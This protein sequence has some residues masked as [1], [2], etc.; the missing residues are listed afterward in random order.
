MYVYIYVNLFFLQKIM[1][2]LAKKLEATVQADNNDLEEF[3]PNKFFIF[4]RN[5][6]EV[7]CFKDSI[8]YGL[9]SGVAGGIGTYLFTSKSRLSS[10]VFMSTFVGV[11]AVYFSIARYQYEKEHDT[12]PKMQAHLQKQLVLEGTK[13]VPKRKLEEILKDV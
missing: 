6:G 11:T 10:H 13:D 5:V 9:Y 1:E 4:G 12:I 2:D 7:P 8:F 3:I